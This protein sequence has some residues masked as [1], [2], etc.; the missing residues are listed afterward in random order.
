MENIVEFTPELIAGIVGVILS[1]VFSWFPVLREIYASLK[2]EVKS[3]IMLLLLAVTSVAIYL[4][5]RYGVIETSEPVTVLKL[6]TVFFMATTL[7]QVAYKIT[8]QAKS[9]KDIQTAKMLAEIR[10]AKLPK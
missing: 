9:V 5:A 4:L 1:W 2:A 7:N 3:G 8:P 10:E 6:I